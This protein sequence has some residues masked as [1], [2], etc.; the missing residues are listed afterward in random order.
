MNYSYENRKE[1]VAC[2]G[3]LLLS[4]P[5]DLPLTMTITLEK[6]GDCSVQIVTD[7]SSED[8]DYQ[9]ARFFSETQ[10]NT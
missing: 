10:V 2:V 3:D 4:L 7:T 6:L 1:L 9:T 8:T 5:K